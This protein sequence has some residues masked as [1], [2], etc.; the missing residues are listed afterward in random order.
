MVNVTII[1]KDTVNVTIIIKNNP[2][3]GRLERRIVQRHAENVS[4]GSPLFRRADDL[5]ELC[6]LQSA[7][8]HSRRRILLGEKLLRS[9]NYR[10]FAIVIC[11]IM[12]PDFI[13]LLEK[14]NER[15]EREQREMARL[16][17]KEA[18]MGSDDGSS[19]IS[20]SH[21]ITDSDT[22]TQIY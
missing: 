18:G 7:G 22:Y 2:D 10:Q 19:R 9:L 11:S 21:S 12:S 20:R 13:S 17:A 1:I 6:P 8:R 14:R 3:P 4:L 5:R 16:A 15:R